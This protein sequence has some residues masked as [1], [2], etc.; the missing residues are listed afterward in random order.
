MKNY[1]KNK[2]GNFFTLSGISIVIKDKLQFELDL[3]DLSTILDRFPKRFL[4]LVDYIIFGEF[5]FLIKQNYNAAFKDGA[6]YVSSIQEGNAS[7]IDDIVHEIGHAVEENHWNEIYS[8]LQ[9]EREFLK[10]RMLLRVELEKNGFRYSS[11]AMSKVEYD[12]HLDKFFYQVVGYPMLTVFSQGIFFSPYAATSLREYFANGFEAF[13]YH[14]DE[15]LSK[16]SPVLYQKIEEL[17]END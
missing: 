13:Y 9:V 12:K 5:E 6:I 1:I 3:E 2:K 10:K 7:V 8:D 16:V 14:R 11:I 17:E 4:K 15:Y